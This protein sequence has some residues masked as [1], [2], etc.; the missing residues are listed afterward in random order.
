MQVLSNPRRAGEF[1]LVSV[2]VIR[3]QQPVQEHAADK[4]DE[5]GSSGHD[6]ADGELLGPPAERGHDL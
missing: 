4:D 1:T 3:R 6:E 5:V 2:T